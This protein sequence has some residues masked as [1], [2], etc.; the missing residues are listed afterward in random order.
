MLDSFKWKKKD[1]DKNTIVLNLCVAICWLRLFDHWSFFFIIRWL[2]TLYAYNETSSATAI[3]LE[4]LIWQQYFY[5]KPFEIFFFYIF[6]YSFCLHHSWKKNLWLITCIL[7]LCV[8]H[9]VYV[10]VCMIKFCHY[11]VFRL[12]R[13]PIIDW[14]DH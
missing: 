2:I 5:S 11:G 10:C 6:S 9:C 12:I 14:N 13:G 1:K 4:L 7:N 3:E 8:L